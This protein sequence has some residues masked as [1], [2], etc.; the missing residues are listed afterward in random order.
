[1]FVTGVTVVL[2]LPL[3]YWLARLQKS[4]AP[5]LLLLASFP[6]WI[7]SVVRS[8]DWVVLLARNGVL[9]RGLQA[10][11]LVGPAFHLLYTLTCCT[12]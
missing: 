6:L 7:S 4:W 9:S 2:G 8:F 11:G 12:R 5:A 3:A 1:M 10:A